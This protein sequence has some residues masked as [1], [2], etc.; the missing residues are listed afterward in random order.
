MSKI[1]PVSLFP[2]TPPGMVAISGSDV[3]SAGQGAEIRHAWRRSTYSG[4]TSNCVETAPDS[5]A[6]L[7]RDSKVVASPVLE[8]DNAAW[9]TFIGVLGA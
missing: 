9:Q 5:N 8:L 3:E 1:K 6:I 4:P 2:A 7:V